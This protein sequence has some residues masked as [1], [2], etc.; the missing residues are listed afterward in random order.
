MSVAVRRSLSSILSIALIATLAF[1]TYTAT[2]ADASHEPANKVA[3]AGSTRQVIGEEAGPEV[4]MQEQ[5]RVSSPAD[6]MIQVQLECSL[7]TDVKTVG[8][9]DQAAGAQ[10]DVWVTVDG[11]PVPVSSV[12][13]LD[14]DGNPI[15]DNGSVTFCNRRYQRTVSGLN[16]GVADDD[17]D[18]DLTI[19]TFLDTKSTH[20][21]NWIALNTGRDGY[22]KD[23]D[24]VLTVQVWADYTEEETSAKANAEAV[25]GNRTLIIEPDNFS[26]H[27]AVVEGPGAGN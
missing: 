5:L 3:V 15:E 7:V 24:N 17:S 22:D 16:N 13:T 20:G 27:E 8:D 26:V 1:T 12:P 21:F 23:G 14:E 11:T 6:L 9:D 25:I 19:E 10:F 18:D 2:R 4:I